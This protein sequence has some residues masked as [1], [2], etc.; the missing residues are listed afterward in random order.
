MSDKVYSNEKL[1]KLVRR[2]L[3]PEILEMKIIVVPDLLHVSLVGEY[4]MALPAGSLISID[5]YT[6]LVAGIKDGDKKDLALD[7]QFVEDEQ[8]TTKTIP[9]K[10]GIINRKLN[11]KILGG[12][13]KLIQSSPDVLISNV[14]LTY[15]PVKRVEIR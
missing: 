2:L 8:L 10:G 15:L 4:T 11:I 13:I 1:T 7:L 14:T 12:F 5:I 6:E 9:I 3:N